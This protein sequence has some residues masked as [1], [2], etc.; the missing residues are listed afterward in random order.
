MIDDAEVV[1]GPAEA[2]ARLTEA[3]DVEVAQKAGAHPRGGSPLRH[4]RMVLLGVIVALALEPVRR[5]SS[6]GRRIFRRVVQLP[7][8]LLWIVVIAVI[9]A[10]F[11]APFETLG[12]WA[13]W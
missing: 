1:V 2:G 13:G 11:M 7:F 12:W 4:R 5:G 10:A 3:A 8:D 6:D 9:V